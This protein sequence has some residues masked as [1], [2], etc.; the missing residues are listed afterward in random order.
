MTSA[1]LRGLDLLER[2]LA[3][4]ET[5]EEA[6]DNWVSGHREWG[7]PGFPMSDEEIRAEAA[8]AW[9][10]GVEADTINR[11]ALATLTAP[12]RR[13]RLRNVDLPCLILHGAQDTLILPEA[14]R[15]I[16]GL[17]P[18]SQ[19]EVIEGMGH[20]ITPSLSPLIIEMVD[21]FIKT[22]AQKYPQ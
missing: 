18:G 11:Q 4:P 14:G 2:V 7:S 8:L 9:D 19:L 12:D 15:E 1:R 13:E 17:I 6:Q 21:T 3:Y 20:V 16:A 5:R 10:R 22:R